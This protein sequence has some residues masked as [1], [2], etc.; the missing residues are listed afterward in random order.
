MNRSSIIFRQAGKV[1][2][3]AHFRRLLA[4]AAVLFAVGSLHT[5]GSAF[6]A[7]TIADDPSDPRPND[8]SLPTAALID[9]N[10]DPLGTLLEQ[11]LLSESQARWLERQEI[12]KEF[13][14][15]LKVIVEFQDLP[16]AESRTM[17]LALH[18]HSPHILNSAEGREFLEQL[19]TVPHDEVRKAAAKLRQGLAAE[20]ARLTRAGTTPRQE[21]A[22][23]TAAPGRELV[24]HPLTLAWHNPQGPVQPLTAPDVWLA[25]EDG[26]DVI[27]D[28]G[29]IYLLKEKGRL[30]RVWASNELNV[31][32]RTYVGQ[33]QGTY[34]CYDGR[35]V[36]AA[37]RRHG[38][39]PLLLV[40]DPATGRVSHI[41][42]DD[43]L[44]L[45]APG[46]LPGQF[47]IQYLAVAPLRPG[48]VCVAGTFG[49]T[50]LALVTFDPQAGKS[51]RV[52]HE[53]RD[54]ADG[55]DKQQWQRTSVAFA[56]AYM[57][58]LTGEP[59]AAGNRPQRVIIGRECQSADVWYHPL[60]VNPESL[61]VEVLAD[62]VDPAEPEGFA[63]HA[64]ALHWPWPARKD[65]SDP[66]TSPSLWKVGFPNFTRT[67]V[68]EHVYEGRAQRFA[69]AFDGP[70]VHV[71]GDRWFTARALGEPFRPLPGP[72]PGP[73]FAQQPVLWRSN[74]YGWLLQLKHSRRVYQVEVP[75]GP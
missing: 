32:F 20:E 46:E 53:A 30:E 60:L 13:A 65:A 63:V 73:G 67:R 50:W 25:A 39:P 14:L 41:T 64:G 47:T 29:A 68:A 19:A 17:Q 71:V 3:M 6:T 28:R 12:D 2:I 8:V 1:G 33:S 34:V 11:R 21:P 23:P 62:K 51:V 36:W 57:F 35:Y 43:G 75:E 59:D 42:A 66:N 26:V 4:V 58:T 31:G 74:H 55:E 38:K 54:V 40:L 72:L 52:F 37:A 10:P 56:P 45:A 18:G 61:A 69:I 15:I 49:R 5:G 70:Q 22:S 9:L 16:G 27:C 44:P 7:A 48:Q 24:F